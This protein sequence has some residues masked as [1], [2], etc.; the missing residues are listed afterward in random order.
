MMSVRRIIA[1]TGKELRELRWLSA[2]FA[3]L[4]PLVVTGGALVRAELSARMIS[5]VFDLV[6]V[7]AILALVMG[8][9]QSLDLRSG[10]LRHLRSL[11]LQPGEIVAGKVL[12]VLAAMAVPVVVG[13]GALGVMARHLGNDPPTPGTMASAAWRIALFTL[14]IWSFEVTA[15]SWPRTGVAVVVVVIAVYAGAL[16]L[17]PGLWGYGNVLRLVPAQEGD[18]RLVGAVGAAL[19][20]AGFGLTWTV[21]GLGCR[22]V[23]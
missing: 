16:A 13:V 3:V 21:A 17:I 19:F 2:C 15:D 9:R 8:Q 12:A 1:W 23:E 20:L 22:P 5:P 11:P 4:C 7:T 18:V 14:V 10:T 6:A